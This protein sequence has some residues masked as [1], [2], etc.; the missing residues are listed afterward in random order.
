MQVGCH[1]FSEALSFYKPF[2]NVVVTNL[3]SSDRLTFTNYSWDDMF[4]KH[5]P[6]LLQFQLSRATNLS[7]LVFMRVSCIGCSW[8]LEEQGGRKEGQKL[9]WLHPWN[10]TYFS[11]SSPGCA[12]KEIWAKFTKHFNHFVQKSS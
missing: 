5:I 6:D 9:W 10:S 8:C 3:T 2:C 1:L 11:T 7:L 12:T 4:M